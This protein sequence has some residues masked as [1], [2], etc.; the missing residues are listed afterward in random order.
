M[1]HGGGGGGGRGGQSLLKAA[2]PVLAPAM[3][4][5]VITCCNEISRGGSI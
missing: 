2:E 5:L 1:P 3:H 4:E